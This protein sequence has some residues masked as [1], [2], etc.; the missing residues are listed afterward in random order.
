MK[1]AC[2]VCGGKLRQSRIAGL[3][4]CEDCQFTSANLKISEEQLEQLYTATYFAGDEYRDYVADRSVVEK[5]FRLRLKKFLKFVP[6]AKEKHLFEIG[7]AHGFFLSLAQE[8][9][10]SVEGIDISVDAIEYARQVFELNA[11]SSNFLDY[12]LATTPYVVCMWDTIEHLR[13][14]DL[15]IEKIADLLPRGGVLALTT[16]DL[17]SWM[18]R[19]RGARWRQIHPPT[20]MH[21]FSRSTLTRLLKRNGL[22]VK[23]MHSEGFFRRVDTMAYIILCLKNNRPKLYSSL[24][25]TGLLN[26][27]LYLNFGDIVF[28]VAEKI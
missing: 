18:A 27:D 28:L 7:C 2:L 23:C 9:F 6:D 3:L 8:K 17:D 1:C 22:E 4:T 26:W 14:P 5:Q 13:R 10:R 19:M 12:E 15:Y 16:G 21:Y 11:R 25:K 20:H 24:K